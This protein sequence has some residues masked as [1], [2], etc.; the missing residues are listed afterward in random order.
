MTPHR[1][2]RSMNA[3]AAVMA[4]VALT[5]FIA[6]AAHLTGGDSGAGIPEGIIAVVLAAGAAVVWPDTA[7]AGKRARQRTVGL[8]TTGFAI[9]GFL[10]GLSETIQGG[11]P[12][13]LAYH[14]TM[15]PV[16]VATFIVLWRSSAPAP[17]GRAGA[18][19]ASSERHATIRP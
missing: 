14:L 17:G 1:T 9:V 4:F 12:A 3:M 7:T 5:L 19:Q 15:L 16:L 11:D 10:V 13:N 6:S 8:I 18:P 2:I